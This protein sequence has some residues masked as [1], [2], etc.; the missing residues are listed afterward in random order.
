MDWDAAS[1]RNTNLRWYELAAIR[2]RKKSN[3]Y[4]A[5]IRCAYKEYHF[6]D[7]AHKRLIIERFLGAGLFPT[8]V[9]CRTIVKKCWR[10]ME[11]DIKEAWTFR[12][13]YQNDVPRIGDFATLP[14][15]AP[16]DSEEE[17][18]ICLRMECD[19]IVNDIASTMLKPT[20]SDS[21]QNLHVSLPIRDRVGLKLFTKLTMSPYVRRRVFGESLS[22][23][24]KKEIISSNTKN[25]PGYVH[26][27][28][29]QRVDE[30]LRLSDVNF[31]RQHDLRHDRHFVLTS[32]AILL[33]N[34]DQQFKVYGW[35]ETAHQIKF[36][37]CDDDDSPGVFIT[38]PKPKFVVE[39]LEQE[40]VYGVSRSRCRKNR[41]YSFNDL[42]YSNSEYRYSQFHPVCI[43]VSSKKQFNVRVLAPRFCYTEGNDGSIF[44]VS[45]LST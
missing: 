32:S 29:A 12:A 21:K 23:L 9:S 14:I 11:P 6:S 2:Q 45:H 1:I 30:V 16:L 24:P 38:L 44:I 19:T 34:A 37:Y 33:N 28:S 10:L 25:D 41:Y 4:T 22:N 15:N 18:R 26:L 5:F 7:M 20:N 17:L 36:I 39:S 42:D 43:A 40:D 31:I 13:N 3:C 8:D 27:F 35:T